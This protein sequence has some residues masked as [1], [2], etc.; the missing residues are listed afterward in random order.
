VSRALIAVALT[1]SVLVAIDQPATAAAPKQAGKAVGGPASGVVTLITGDRVLVRGTEYSVEKNPARKDVTF[2]SYIHDGHLNVLPSDAM[3]L[4]GTKLDERLF[5]VTALMEAG[6]G[7]GRELG[8][9]VKHD[10]SAKASA[11]SSVAKSGGK[12]AREL[13]S[14]NALAVRATSAQAGALWT[15]L[16]T[17]NARGRQLRSGVAKV[18][19]DGVQRLS[20]DQSVPQVGAPTAWAA[21]FDG[22]GV[23]VG[24]V[25]SGV[26]STH[27]DLD[28]KVVAAADF[29][30]EGLLDLNGHGTHVAS[31]LAGTGA[32]SGGLLKG[33]APGAQLVSAK[34]CVATG[35]CPDSAIIEAMEWAADQGVDVINMSLGGADRAGIDPLE[36]AVNTLTDS[37]G[38]LFVIAAGNT[39]GPGP[40]PF[41]VSSPST[42]DAALSVGAVD[43]GNGLAF[44]SN[45]GPRVGD[46]ALKPDITAPGIA[47]TAA[48]SS[49]SSLPGGLYT[50]LN[51]TSMASPHVAGA[52]AILAQRHPTWT[53]AQIKAALMG[54]AFQPPNNTQVFFQ[55]AGRLDVARGYNQTVLA[56]PPSVS[57]GRQLGPHGDDPVLTRTIT[58]TNTNTGS[59]VNLSLSLVTQGPTGAPAEPDM[60]ELS[61]NS[62]T[63]APGGTATVDLITTTSVSAPDGF[64]GGWVIATGQAG[65]VT[66]S[67]PFAVHRSPPGKEITFNHL[68][69]SGDFQEGYVTLLM[70][71]TA[72]KPVYVFV[73]LLGFGPVGPRTE[74]VEFGDYLWV[75]SIPEPGADDF[76]ALVQPKLT[77]DAST[78]SEIDLDASTAQPVNITVPDAAAHTFEQNLG[79]GYLDRPDVGVW[80]GARRQFFTKQLGPPNVFT[81]GFLTRVTQQSYVPAPGRTDERNATSTYNVAWFVDQVFPTGFTRNVT[82][83]QLARRDVTYGFNLPGGMAF[84][85]TTPH[86]QGGLLN[87]NLL[88]NPWTFDLPFSRSEFYNTESNIRWSSLF[89]ERN[90]GAG[91]DL[92]LLEQSPTSYTAGTTGTDAWNTPVSGPFLGT[93]MR[94]E[95]WVVRRGD[96]MLILPPMLSDSGGHPGFPATGFPVPGLTGQSVLKRNGVVVATLPYAVGHLP[97]RP[98]VAVPAAFSTYTLET[99]VS[100][101]AVELATTVSAVWT[102]TSATVDPNSVLPMALWAVTFKPNLSAT[103]TAPAGSFAIPLTAAAQPGSPAAGINTITVQYS[104]D[105]GTTWQNATVTGSGANRTA[106]VTNPA[107]GYVSL[108]AT[109][110]DFAGN[111]V[112][113][114]TIR[115]YK[116]G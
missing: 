35:G 86:P 40:Q 98:S 87:P 25:D 65:G 31:T 107:S 105:D 39:G 54:S 73:S 50:D 3:G 72:G 57:L 79:V 49:H 64:Y 95:D 48:R 27:P 68:N 81:N 91:A 109:A 116:I 18:W 23:T 92:V 38:T 102:F 19:L 51:G 60:F 114:T 75:N 70:P 16:T 52:A 85:Q 111:S 113:Q 32:G 76:T 36:E 37:H 1:G 71:L 55:G 80:L 63:L 9:I 46:T 17:G 67:T 97:P 5:D 103:N 12:V 89:S 44:F 66:V 20:L 10:K 26:D 4:I 6:Y 112:T 24:V 88:P 53:P 28:G 69:R 101:G 45:R 115:A 56:N 22:T 83:G 41:S 84:K 33:V 93:R 94:P 110:T 42:A 74:F 59:G 2:V 104:T 7:D 96:T 108:R 34:A 99:T 78:P 11:R 13:K 15:E 47:I 43:P 61:T 90:P 8:L 58:Y 106:T 29:T 82:S 100:R 62:I 21:G 77:V 30:G 14:V